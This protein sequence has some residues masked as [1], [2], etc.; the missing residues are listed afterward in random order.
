MEGRRHYT[1]LAVIISE[2][3]WY[4]SFGVGRGDRNSLLKKHKFRNRT[5]TLIPQNIV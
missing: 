1:E 5:D 4:S 2:K 3:G